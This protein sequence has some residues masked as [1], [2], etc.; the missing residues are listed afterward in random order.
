MKCRAKVAVLLF[1]VSAIM[2]SAQSAPKGQ[3]GTQETQ[4]RGVWIDQSTGLMWA[5][6]DNGKDVSWK[7][8]VKYWCGEVLP[9]SL[10]GRVLGLEAGD[11]C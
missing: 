8:A 7:G 5:G 4:K 3:G 9:R 1:S 10:V 2:A 6:K 11:T